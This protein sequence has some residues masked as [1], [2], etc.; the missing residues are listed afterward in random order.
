MFILWRV[1]ML[2]GLSPDMCSV[3]I[4]LY[5]TFMKAVFLMTFFFELGCD[6]VLLHMCVLDLELEAP[7]Y[8]QWSACDQILHACG[9]H[10]KALGDRTFIPKALELDL[11]LL[12]LDNKHTYWHWPASVLDESWLQFDAKFFN[13]QRGICNV[14]QLVMDKIYACHSLPTNFW[15]VS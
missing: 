5:C 14:Y 11:P 13:Q 8:G 2:L 6:E 12:S 1:V 7:K 4:S 3:T 10:C 15:N 9:A